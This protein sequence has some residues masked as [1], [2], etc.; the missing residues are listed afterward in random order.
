MSKKVQRI[1]LEITALLVGSAAYAS[2]LYCI[3]DKN[4]LAPGGISGISVMV[5]YINPKIAVGT[6]Y[7]VLNIPI[8][9]LGF[10]CLSRK[11]MFYTL[12]ATGMV[13][14]F[15]NLLSYLAEKEIWDPSLTDIPIL[16]ALY[17]GAALG[18][19]V[20][21][22]MRGGGS[23]GGTDI[24]AKVV[25]LRNKQF[26]TGPLILCAD[27]VVITA[28]AF[29]FQDIETAL[30]AGVGAVVSAKILDLVLYG[31][32]ETKKLLIVSEHHEAIAQRFMKELDTGVTYLDG[33][34]AY[35]GEP[36]TVMLCMV[37][38]HLFTKAREIVTEEDKNAFLII[39]S[40]SEVFGEG[41]KRHE[42]EDL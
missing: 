34:G 25:R 7:L 39:S 40:A 28:S 26:R 38:K 22:V 30:Y 4:H 9:I 37:K 15:S 21:I 10:I 20:G 27:A 29:V 24:L 1:L 12:I 32:D 3:M 17:G 36:R 13:S 11:F 18:V 2:A 8:L 33:R 35:T 19:G 14:G 5:H 41:Y 6:T 23:T 42:S 16:A 31:S